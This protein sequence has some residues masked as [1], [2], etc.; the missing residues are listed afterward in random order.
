MATFT[1]AKAQV[2]QDPDE[3]YAQTDTKVAFALRYKAAMA[4][5]YHS[6][7]KR[8]ESL[9][10]VLI[11]I[12][13]QYRYITHLT[14]PMY[15]NGF[16]FWPEKKISQILAIVAKTFSMTIISE[17]HPKSIYFLRSDVFPGRYAS[18]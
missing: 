1:Q 4:F 10:T 14:R 7:K 9:Y 18:K 16:L 3:T 15:T 13:I 12:D 11:A 8:E 5:V 6:W 17:L 2:P